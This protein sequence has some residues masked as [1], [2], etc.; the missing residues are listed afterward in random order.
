M[1]PPVAG[2]AR[3]PRPPDGIAPGPMI[4]F[5]FDGTATL[6]EE[7][8]LP[9]VRAYREDLAAFFHLSAAECDA[10][11]DALLAE[12]AA[13]PERWPFRMGGRAVCPA[14]VD[15]YL[16]MSAIFDTLCDQLGALPDPADR[17][18]VSGGLLYRK[19]YELTLH[20]PVFRPEAGEVFAAL[21][22]RPVY[23][24]TNSGTGHVQ[25]KVAALGQEW[26]RE[27]V[28]GNA[29]KFVVDDTFTDVPAE[30]TLPGLDRPVLL[31]RRAY[32]DLLD[33]LRR[34]EGVAWADVWV[35]GDIF[36]LDLALPMAMGARV[37]LVDSAHTPP[38][39]R[40]WVRAHGHL[41]SSLREARL[42]LG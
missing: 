14:A 8:A 7:E 15:P 6:A 21:Q 36:E 32:H 19:N 35:V 38:W 22:G 42:L 40:A 26:L 24:V 20:R 9:F 33:R 11:V 18:R 25:A 17:A 10:R 3:G 34:A 41:V 2:R 23:V 29:R 31:R 30:L 16:R 1:S 12:I 39:E 4:V 5:D 27:R 13:A 37:V 28:Y